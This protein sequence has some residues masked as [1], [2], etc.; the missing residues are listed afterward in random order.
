MLKRIQ[1]PR[2]RLAGQAVATAVLAS[3]VALVPVVAQNAPAEAADATS[4]TLFPAAQKALGAGYEASG[5]LMVSGT[6][7]SDGFHI[8]AASEQDGYTFREVASLR[9]KDMDVGPW[10]GYVC[11]TGSGKYAAAVYMPSL[12]VNK[13]GATYRGAFA[14]VVRLSDGKVTEVAQGVQLAYFSPGCGEDDRVLFSSSTATDSSPGTT[15]VIE[16]DAATGRITSDRKINGRVTHLLPTARG[17]YGVLGGDLVKLAA[18]GKTL[19]ARKQTKLPG[20]V[21]ALTSSADGALDLGLVN[22][23]KSVI[24]RWQGGKLTA[25]GSAPVG[26]LKL[27]PRKGGSLAVGDVGDVDTSHAPGL[28]T[29]PFTGQPMG[30]SREGHLVTTSV[31]S[32]EL[33]GV[34]TPEGSG[35]G[36][37]SADGKAAGLIRIKATAVRTGTKA[38]VAFD[39]D[40]ERV[41]PA[42]GTAGSPAMGPAAFT[43][44]TGPTAGPATFGAAA[45]SAGRD[46][47]DPLTC[48]EGAAESLCLSGSGAAVYGEI[49]AM[50]IPCLVKRNDPK[51]Q[52]LQPSANMVEWAVDQAVHGNLTTQRPANWHDTGL[53]AYSPQGLFPKPALSG[54]GNIPA[55]VVL[56]IL[57]Q[58]SNFKQA[59]WHSVNGAAG[60][61]L[62][63]DWFGNEASIHYYPNRDKGDCGYGIA[64]VTTG[65]SEKH[66][67]RFDATRAGAISTDYATNIAAGIQILAEKWNQLY[68]LGMETNSND[69]QYLENWYMALWAY[70]SGVYT[71]PSAPRGL[72]YFNNPAN[73]SYPPDRAGFLRLSYDDAAHPAKWPY[74]EKVLGW[75]ETPHKTWN[76]EESYETPDFPGLLSVQ[77]NLPPDPYRF[78]APNVNNCTPN[79]ADPCPAFNDTCRWAGSVSWIGGQN[80]DNSSREDLT[81]ELGSGEPAL[82]AKYPSGPCLSKPNNNPYAIVVDDLNEHEDV[83]G[84]G[85]FE[86][87]PD[88]KFSLQLGDNLTKLRTDGTFRATPYI[89]QIDL[90]QLGAGYDGH[91]FFTHSYPESDFFHKVTARWELNPK[92]LPAADDVGNRYNVWVHLPNHGAQAVVRYTVIPGANSEGAVPDTCRVNQGTRSNGKDTWFKLGS[93]QFWK[94]G[95]VE[96]DNLHDT[97]TGDANV[98]FDAVAFV[99]TSIPD[100]G[101]CAFGY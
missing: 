17:D 31:V 84:C 11:T 48:G 53:P 22:Q 47:V 66:P 76:W 49:P 70:N 101:N 69:P 75:A 3:S 10:T 1:T 64:Q 16:A 99:P 23:K 57:A 74:Q 34:T 87:A 82:I 36:A 55:Q 67:I 61:V 7:D 19:K 24:S 2:R 35:P 94:G 33:K 4:S 8:M 5:D 32:D 58:E 95:R 52:A 98:A 41:K 54:G 6:G 51:R 65:M 50:E 86:G 88:G 37:A 77:L 91:V 90:H 20:P 42:K 83:Y 18:S 71:D 78:C 26:K 21:F 97:G 43:T 29:Q 62:Q 30:V 56:G 9:R 89:A 68:A 39:T 92:S 28:K 46:D 25:L 44:A 81:Y 45:V 59:S 93:V 96:A 15:T 27:F 100:A 40:V 85:D 80:S 60:N 63:A 79:T 13:P 14:A 12:W 38:S 72:G 73:P